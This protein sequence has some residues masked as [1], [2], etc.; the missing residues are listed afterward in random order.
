M[1]SF[2]FNHNF[3]KFHFRL[4]DNTKNNNLSVKK[5]IQQYNSK[6]SEND[7]DNIQMKKLGT[8][9]IRTRSFT[10]LLNRSKIHGSNP[11]TKPNLINNTL[12]SD[13][14]IKTSNIN[15]RNK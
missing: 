5:L 7:R 14:L 8:D 3:T 4:T 9:R 12:I 2:F 15:L 11:I 13:K 10:A 6:C 1:V